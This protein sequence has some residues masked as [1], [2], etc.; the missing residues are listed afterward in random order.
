MSGL[1][2]MAITGNVNCAAVPGYRQRRA[3]IGN[4]GAGVIGSDVPWLECP[5]S[6]AL[7]WV[8][9]VTE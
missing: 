6:N 9:T 2:C 8:I 3:I 5:A 4:G 7:A 1:T